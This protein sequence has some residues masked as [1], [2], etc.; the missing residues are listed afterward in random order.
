MILRYAILSRGK[1]DLLSTTYR[2]VFGWLPILACGGTADR[3]P[4][5]GTSYTGGC[6]R[7]PRRALRWSY[8]SCSVGFRPASLL[9][10]KLP[11]A[12]PACPPNFPPKR[13][14]GRRAESLK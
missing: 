13:L 7:D 2:R 3:F 4:V 9:F 1:L 12:R 8:G 11:R 6:A 10:R 5:A 14:M